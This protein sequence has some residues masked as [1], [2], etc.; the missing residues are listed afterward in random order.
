MLNSSKH[1]RLGTEMEE[2]HPGSRRHQPTECAK[3][4]TE[5]V[6]TEPTSTTI[7]PNRLRRALVVEGEP[8]TVR[9]CRNILE[10]SGFVVDAVGSG[11]AAVVAARKKLPDV[12]FI[13]LQLQDVPG[14]EAVGW[15]RSNPALRSTPIIVLATNA[16]DDADLAAIRADASLRK[17]LSPITIRRTLREVLK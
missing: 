16:E 4:T 9:L 7:S 11:I 10:N 1:T 5:A 6:G 17:P 13:D 14:R 15:L 3:Q 12:I 8:A 2:H